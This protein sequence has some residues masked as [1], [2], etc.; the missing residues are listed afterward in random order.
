MLNTYRLVNRAL[1]AGWRLVERY[2]AIAPGTDRGDGFGTLGAGSCIAFPVASLFNEQSIH[3]GAGTLIGRSCSLSVGYTPDDTRV[4]ERGLVF[5]ERCVVGARGVFSAHSSIT[6]GDDV[7]FGQDVFVSDSSHG[8]QDPETPIGTQ[9]GEHLPV[10]IGTGSWVGHGA[11]IL[12]GTT[13]G[14]N[15]VVAAG[16]VVRGVVEDHAVVAGVPARVI[17]RLDPEVGWTN[18][19]GDDVRP[20]WRSS[21]VSAVLAGE[22]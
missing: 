22:A 18:A 6:V 21:E 19:A 15:V 1:H 13:L 11:I 3:V 9:L 2:G 4:P 20:V 10:S 14:R 5:G 12:P 16:S 17:R 8:Y 7:W